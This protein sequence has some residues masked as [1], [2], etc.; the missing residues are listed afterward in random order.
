VGPHVINSCPS[1]IARFSCL[2]SG[3]ATFSL[4]PPRPAPLP[5]ILLC[6][7]V[8]KPPPVILPSPV[9]TNLS[10]YAAPPGLISGSQAHT[11]DCQIG[12]GGA[13]PPHCSRVAQA[14]MVVA[15]GQAGY[16]GHV[17]C[18]S[19]RRELGMHGSQVTQGPDVSK[20]CQLS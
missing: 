11:R 1:S 13:D 7:Y 18:R 10:S 4:P 16:R 17:L 2:L 3:A 15:H 9:F 8:L 6:P 20:A 19:R 5:A 14:P 12:G